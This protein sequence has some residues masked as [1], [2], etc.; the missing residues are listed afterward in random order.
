[1]TVIAIIIYSSARAS[2]PTTSSPGTSLGLRDA[3]VAAGVATVM[4]PVLAPVGIG[5]AVAAAGA[6]GAAGVAGAAGA[7]GVAT[8]AVWTGTF[9]TASAY[10]RALRRRNSSS[11]NGEQEDNQNQDEQ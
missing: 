10:L 1:M 8:A 2:S 4:T 11:N 5:A 6:A 3:L 9:A 7:A